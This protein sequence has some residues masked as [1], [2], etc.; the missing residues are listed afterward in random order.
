MAKGLFNPVSLTQH[1]TELNIVL[2]QYLHLETVIDERMH[3]E[4]M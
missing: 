1:F 2:M 3:G 4:E